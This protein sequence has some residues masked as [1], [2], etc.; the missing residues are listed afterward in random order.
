MIG[1]WFWRLVALFRKIPTG[2]TY[3]GVMMKM[4]STEF[5][6]IK[7][8]Y[9][10]LS[11]YFL[12]IQ[13]IRNETQLTLL[14][15]WIRLFIYFYLLISWLIYFFLDFFFVYH[16]FFHSHI[17]ESKR[18]ALSISFVCSKRPFWRQ[19]YLNVS[20]NWHL[21]PPH[22]KT[23]IQINLHLICLIFNL[24]LFCV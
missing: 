16:I 23:S 7:V 15:E 24:F 20:A 3:H 2:I 9:S 18:N 5:R 11:Y 13:A 17:V 8:K 12:Y 6:W 10:L 21:T 14:L 1:V 22:F 19:H 4:W